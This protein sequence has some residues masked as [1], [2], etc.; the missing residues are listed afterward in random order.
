MIYVTGDTHGFL[1]FDKIIQAIKANQI[2]SGDYLI[3]AGDFGGVW[4]KTSLSHTISLI[5]ALPCTI[6]FVDGNHENFDII[7][8]FPITYW[9]NGKIH[10]ISHNLFHLM[11]GQVY[12]I[13]NISILALGGA[14][15]T[16][17]EYRIPFVSWWPNESINIGDIIEAKTNL[18]NLRH[19]DYIV[20]H[21][22]AEQHIVDVMLELRKDRK[23]QTSEILLNNLCDMCTF[24]QWYFGHWHMDLQISNNVRAVYNDIIRLD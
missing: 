21:T 18:G 5:D 7:N 1:N 22:C 3:I 9:N 10:K 17:K 13:N 15:S 20:T 6:L 2:K 14:E 12:L 16:D 23:I 4:D 11:R 24:K 19:V 8:S